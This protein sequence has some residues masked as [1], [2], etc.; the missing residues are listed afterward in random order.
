MSVNDT[1]LSKKTR[2]SHNAL[3]PKHQAIFLSNEI[4]LILPPKKTNVTLKKERGQF[5]N[6]VQ[7]LHIM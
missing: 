6:G 2:A 5:P 7:S 3:I 4:Y 1:F